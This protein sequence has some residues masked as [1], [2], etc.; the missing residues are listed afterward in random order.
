MK[1]KMK[2]GTKIRGAFLT[3]FLLL[4]CAAALAW[5]EI[6]QVDHTYSSLLDTE[7]VSMTRVKEL[8]AELNQQSSEARG[9]L[10]TG[11]EA[12]MAEYQE[13]ANKFEKNVLLI[14]S[15][16]KDPEFIKLVKKID[17]LQGDYNMVIEKEV[18]A[19]KAENTNLYMTIVK[20]SAKDVGANFREA[21]DKAVEY[22]IKKVDQVSSEANHAT[23]QTQWIVIAISIFSL[24]AALTLSYL[25]NHAITKPII[26]ASKAINKV[27]DGDL[28]VNEIKVKNKDEIGTL[29]A[30]L[31]HMVRNLRTI[32]GEVNQSASHVA[33]SS[34]QLAAS[35]EE[36]TAA[37]E[38]IAHNTQR[39]SQG[40]EIQLQQFETVSLSVSHMTSG[41]EQI[42]ENSND[43]LSASE[44]A[45]AV[46]KKGTQSIANVVNQ[47]GLIHGSV[48]EASEYIQ[49]LDVRSAEIS[50]IVSLITGI[51]DQ[52][53]LLAL[54]AAIEAARAGE[55]GR[56]FAVVA[57]EVRKLAEESKRS[58]DQITNMIILIQDEIKQA[59]QSMEKGSQLVNDGL[60]ESAEA[61]AAFD[62]ISHSIE[63]VTSKVKE[64][65][66]SVQELTASSGQITE[67]V[68]EVREINQTS[69]AA[70]LESSAATEEQLATMEEVTASAEALSKLAEDL[71]STISHFKM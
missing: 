13:S 50:N 8:K 28:A 38:Q 37:A 31:N 53:N 17:E 71:Q 6:G 56:G 55:Q 36:S 34:E 60:T 49:S 63:S 27:A 19:K 67:A 12:N 32:V 54:N 33:A 21:V 10:I 39:A 40:M 59:V 45:G 16:S 18:Q 1:L 43:M 22:Q 68:L 29:I 41:L 14:L 44:E 35:S 2:V 30:S 15:Q 62:S 5:Y 58:A 64:V 66:A 24:A 11:D 57:D 69:A 47:M 52:T 20:T 26:A 51:A 61:N 4:G 70:T 65:S 48:S 42:S 9:F 25:V 3:L 23:K 7:V 46:T